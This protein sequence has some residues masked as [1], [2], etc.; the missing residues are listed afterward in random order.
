MPTAQ[1]IGM[2]LY[3]PFIPPQTQAKLMAVQQQEAL[4]EALLEEGRKPV[5]TDNRSIN[6]VGYAVSPLEGLAK[7]MQSGVGAYQQNKANEA[8]ANILNPSQTSSSG[9]DENPSGTPGTYQSPNAVTQGGNP[10]QV[11][12]QGL[13]SQFGMSQAEAWQVL[14]DPSALGR[15][16]AGIKTPEMKNAEF[17]FGAQAPQIVRQNMQNELGKGYYAANPGQQSLATA[18]GTNAAGLLPPG[19][20]PQGMNPMMP[21]LINAES[22]GNPNAV[23]PVGAQGLAQ[24]M[25]A[26]GANPGFGVTPLQNGS[27][28]ENVRF[29]NDYLNAMQNRYQ[30][31]RLAAAAYNAGPSRVDAALKQLPQETQDYVQKV[32]PQIIAQATQLPP[33]QPSP[34]ASVSGPG[35]PSPAPQN[36][37]TM[38]AYKA[39]KDAWAEGQKAQAQVGP[40]GEKAQAEEHG[41]NNAEAERAVAAILGRLTSAN[42]ILDKMNG[43]A[44]QVPY[45]PGVETQRDIGNAFKRPS[46][47]AYDEFNKYNENLFVQELPAIV[48]NSGGRIDIPLV[49]SIQEASKI[50]MDAQPNT[51]KSLVSD[52]RGLLGKVRDNALQNY[53]AQ[54]GQDFNLGKVFD[55]PDSIKQAFQSGVITQDQAKLLLQKNHGFK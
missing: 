14:Q 46:A 52:T 27:S 24:V 7:M 5:S 43:L 20:M 39:A 36:Y 51:K 32:A 44:D 49:K 23:S 18:A 11:A 50:P 6:G 22:G 1:Q 34:L 21:A 2:Q 55:S 54:T 4:A 38:D 42:G 8:Y 40:A 30:D 9:T 10:M 26:T 19:A 45:G 12:M 53:K 28:Q 47:T 17:A 3:N 29:G 33:P 48:Q 37:P 41:K 16:Y 25:P 15:L 31:P 35:T 13:M